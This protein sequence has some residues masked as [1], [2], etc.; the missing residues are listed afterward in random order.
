MNEEK[1][2]HPLSIAA[3]A[4]NIIWGIAGFIGSIVLL[5]SEVAFGDDVLTL[6]GILGIF[7]SLLI[8]FFSIGFSA[9]LSKG[10]YPCGI[11][12]TCLVLS[13][14]LCS[15][16]ATITF[17]VDLAQNSGPKQYVIVTQNGGQSLQQSKPQ[18]VQQKQNVKIDSKLE[19]KLAKLK[20]LKEKGLLSEEEYNSMQQATLKELL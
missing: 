18:T 19:E 10:K 9:E 7:F 17:I 1:R 15:I 14:L 12:T 13:C 8:L 20:A 5:A 4:V 11:A 2:K 3:A 6:V 16:F